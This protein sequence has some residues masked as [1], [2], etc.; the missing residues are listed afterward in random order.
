LVARPFGETAREPALRQCFTRLVDIGPVDRNELTFVG[1]D[2][3]LR[4]NR[5]PSPPQLLLSLRS[6]T[7]TV[8]RNSGETPWRE[9]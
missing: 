2:S 4:S 9:V 7:P 3:I 5:D 6:P 8:K 1:I